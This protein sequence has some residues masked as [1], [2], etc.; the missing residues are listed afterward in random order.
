[1]TISTDLTISHG[2]SS[3]VPKY[4]LNWKILEATVH[5]FRRQRWT[6]KV[7]I[8]VHPLNYKSEKQKDIIS[9]RKNSKHTKREDRKCSTCIDE[10]ENHFCLNTE[11]LRH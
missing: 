4:W 2:M 1:M 9:I 7:N 6:I 5:E 8:H 11:K 10:I 3:I